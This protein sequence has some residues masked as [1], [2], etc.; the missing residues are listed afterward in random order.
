MS[1]SSTQRG[2]ASRRKRGRAARRSR[3]LQ[4]ENE[5]SDVGADARTDAPPAGPE[6]LREGQW[7]VSTGEVALE[8]DPYT[9]DTWTVLVNRV[10]SSSITLSD[11]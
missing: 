10:P 8:R 7:P 4:G 1:G 9:P 2:G 6:D 3:L 11:P 5:A